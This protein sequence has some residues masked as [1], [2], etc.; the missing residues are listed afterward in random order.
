V[1]GLLR[2][3][4]AG[5]SDLHNRWWFS[6]LCVQLYFG[7]ANRDVNTMS[8][9][10]KFFSTL[11]AAEKYAVFG[12]KKL[13][14]EI[15]RIADSGQLPALRSI[16]GGSVGVPNYQYDAK[17]ESCTSPVSPARRR[18]WSSRSPTRIRQN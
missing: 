9:E 15:G 10:C 8:L 11:K 12:L 2:S 17:N 7:G 3:E 14:P 4:A 6:G 16:I 1:I 18:R 5:I 13:I